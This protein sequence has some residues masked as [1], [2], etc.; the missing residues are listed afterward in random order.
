NLNL[1]QTCSNSRKRNTRL[2]LV[3]FCS[4]ILLL[5]SR[6]DP[7]ALLQWGV[8]NTGPADTAIAVDTGLALDIGSS[9]GGGDRSDGSEGTVIAV[10]TGF[11]LEIGSSDGGGDRSDDHSS[12]LDRDEEE[13][14][15]SPGQLRSRKQLVVTQATDMYSILK[16]ER[17]IIAKEMHGYTF[18]SKLPVRSA[19]E[20][21]P[22]QGGRPVR[23]IVITTWRSGS[24]FVGD[25]LSILPLTY[26]HN[27]PLMDFGIKQVRTGTNAIQ[28]LYT[29]RQLLNCNYTDMKHYLNCQHEH[30][31]LLNPNAPLWKHCVTRLDL[32][33]RPEF[34]SSFCSLFPFQTIKTVRLRLNLTK[35]FLEDIKLITQKVL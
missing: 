17:E 8:K 5:N 21:I 31:W 29:I 24:T 4:T 32:C 16:R 30:P 9:D 7:R 13:D 1:R 14:A 18:H 34:L 6:T 27:E 3:L 23:S 35:G 25:I 10:D 12:S 33:R 26:Y 22:E 28:A 15:G 2:L 11:V 20:L 19:G